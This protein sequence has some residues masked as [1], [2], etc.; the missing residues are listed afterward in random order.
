MR[1]QI[2]KTVCTQDMCC[3][4]M[5]CLSACNKDAI[6]IVDELKVYNAIK[7][8]NCIDCGI[9]ENICPQNNDISVKEPIAWKQ[10][11]SRNDNNRGSSASGGAA[12]E[13]S[14][15]F[16]QNGGIVCSCSFKD[17]IFG[18]SFVETIDELKQ[19]AGSKYVKS[20]PNGV[21]K[22]IKQNLKDNHRILFIGL[23]C[24]VAAVKK[25]VGIK[26]QDNL[27]T[28]DLICHG[29]PS[30][31]VLELFLNQYKVK[32]KALTDIQFRSKMYYKERFADYSGFASSGTDDRYIL[33]FLHSLS[34]TDNCYSCK[35]ARKERVS[36]VTIGDSWGSSESLNEEKKGISLALIQTKK[37][38]ELLNKTNIE[39]K[40]VNISDAVANNSQLRHPSIMPPKRDLFF[41]LLNKGI[42]FNTS[43]FKSL[44]KECVRQWI[45]LVFIKLG[46]KK[47][48][49]LNYRIIIKK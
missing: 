28:I 49:G 35:Y 36:D 42:S 9:C 1:N 32:L 40:E 14:K 31:K 25:F 3:G 23:P 26:L 37:G 43:V 41:R 27:Y 30:P 19:F 17:G 18:F 6:S 45:K 5:A 12:A 34:Y 4:C 11:W 8:D 10:G 48:V 13:I 47:V 24:Q 29:T 44:K 2:L 20:N 21:Y 38:L 39:F 22:V 46:L 15:T 16:V 33:S 7:N